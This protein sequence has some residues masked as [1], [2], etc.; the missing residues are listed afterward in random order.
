MSISFF[1]LDKRVQQTNQ[2]TN[3]FK[4]YNL[5]KQER[6]GT[7]WMALQVYNPNDLKIK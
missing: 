7:C 6:Y 4:E 2:Q 5:Q 3:Q 1:I